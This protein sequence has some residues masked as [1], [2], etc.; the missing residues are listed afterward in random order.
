MQT[1]LTHL[2]LAAMLGGLAASG[3]LTSAL[4]QDKE[5]PKADTP[6]TFKFTGKLGTVTVE[7]K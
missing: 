1:K 2:A 3:H 7:L 6:Q 5:Q 4:A